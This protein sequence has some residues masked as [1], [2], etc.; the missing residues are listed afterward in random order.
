[1]NVTK[2]K[3]NPQNDTRQ[4]LKLKQAAQNNMRKESY[5]ATQSILYRDTLT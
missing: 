1:M 2:T 4:K 3:E 5:L